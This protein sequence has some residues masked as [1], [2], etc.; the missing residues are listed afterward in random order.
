MGKHKKEN[1]RQY[2]RK[3][4]FSKTPLRTQYNYR[5]VFQILPIDS[6][7]A[8]TSPYAKDF[9]LFLEYY[10]DYKDNIPDNIFNKI[11]IQQK[12]VLEI[13]NLLS[14]LTN[15]RF[16]EYQ[17]DNMMWAV[18]TPNVDFDNINEEDKKRY[19]DQYCSWCIGGYVYP[20]L[21]DELKINNFSEEKYPQTE[22]ISPYYQYFTNNPVEDIKGEI[23]FPETITDCLDCYFKLSDKTLHKVKSC[24]Y[25]TCD[26]ID[27][28]DRKRSLGFLSYISAIEGLVGLEMSD[29]E[30]IFECKSCQ[31][32]KESPYHCQQCGRPIWGIKKKFVEFLRKFV[33]GSEKSAKTYK[34]I[35]DLRSK[36]THMSQLFIGDYELSLEQEHI[37]IENEDWLMRLKTLQLLRLSLSSWLQYPQ[38][39]N[40]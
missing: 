3:V 25:L 28:S 2:Y 35:Y 18:T 34:E 36:I 40:N 14:T 24:I 31:A 16:F 17:G 15:H 19:I 26:G 11:S 5:D 10:I 39:R 37:K 21:K 6:N 27:I 23:R 1:M 13:V 4:I 32:I 22:L 7:F 29:E 8:P 30:I 20:E 12:K 33:A 9:P 38:K